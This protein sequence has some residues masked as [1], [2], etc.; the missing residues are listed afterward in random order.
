MNLIK[1]VVPSNRLC[2]IRTEQYGSS[3][4]K[5]LQFFAEAKKDFPS[6]EPKDVE[7]VRYGG[8]RYAKTFGL[9]F[10][11]PTGAEIP[12]TYREIDHVEFT[13]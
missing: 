8:E 6:L 13:Q 9:E 10:T 7:I 2:I 11:A 12:S 5:F 1:E 3:L 4:Q